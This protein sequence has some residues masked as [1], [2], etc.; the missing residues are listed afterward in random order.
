MSNNLH[1]PILL[2]HSVSSCFTLYND[3]V[4]FA[5]RVVSINKSS[6]SGMD[7]VHDAI[8]FG[9]IN[10]DNYK[11]V[12]YS[13]FYKE[14]SH[15]I[16]HQEFTGYEYSYKSE[17]KLIPCKYCMQELPHHEF[18]TI[19]SKDGITRLFTTSCI[20]CE[21]IGARFRIKKFTKK[22]TLVLGDYYIKKSICRHSKTSMSNI[23]K[24][25]IEI[26]RTEILLNRISKS[27][28]YK[29]YGQYRRKKT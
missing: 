14:K 2:K 10:D 1:Q 18:R 17:T 24:E 22:Q 19:T 28:N 12:I 13:F 7:I 21:P 4:S 11:K 9:E 27:F 26:K 20:K 23:N 25:D 15:E 8:A 6:V 5:N 3:A 16:L 29:R